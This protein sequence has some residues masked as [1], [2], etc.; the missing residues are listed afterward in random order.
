[1][2]VGRHR[3]NRWTRAAGPLNCGLRISNCGFEIAPPRQLRRYPLALGFA[4]MVIKK[5]VPI[6]CLLLA[7]YVAV[8]AKVPQAP[9]AP[10]KLRGMVLDPQK[11]YVPGAT[12][13]IKGRRV[14]RQLYSADDGSYSIELPPGM[15][16]VRIAHPGFLPFRKRVQIKSNGVANLDVT[17]RL[18]PRL[19]GKT[20]IVTKRG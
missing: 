15:Y 12:I 2:I 9:A 1:M 19:F 11:I 3:T 10:G 16:I 14:R 20:W 7:L 4:K 13:T 5:L 17:F 8:H 18:N 6:A